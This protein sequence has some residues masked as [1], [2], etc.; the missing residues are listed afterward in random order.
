MEVICPYHDCCNHLKEK[1]DGGISPYDKC[2]HK[3][4]HFEMGNCKIPCEGQDDADNKPCSVLKLRK[5]KIIKIINNKNKN[6]EN[7]ES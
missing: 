3:N 5:N 6:Y 1:L 4:P 2:E 7:S